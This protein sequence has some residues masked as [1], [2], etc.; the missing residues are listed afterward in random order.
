M[1]TIKHIT[2]IGCLI[3]SG[4]LLSSCSSGTIMDNPEMYKNQVRGWIDRTLVDPK[5][6]DAVKNL[7]VYYMQTHNN[8]K[9]RYYLGEALDIKPDDPELIFYKGLNLEFYNQPDK[10]ISFYEKYKEVPEDS[11]Y[12]ELLEGRYLWIKRQQNYSD[13]SSLIQNEK[14]LTFNNVSDSTMAVFPLIYDGTNK[15]YAPL[16]RGFSEMVSIDL[17]KLKDI[18]VLERVRIQAVLDELKLSQSKEV[19]QSTA[20]RV[21]KI[22]K[23]GTIV[24]GDYDVT[25]NGDFKI[26]LGSWEVE[27]SQRKSWVNKS[28]SLKDLF[29][30]QKQVVFAFLQEN[31]FQLTQED[32]EK[33]AYIPTQNLEAFLAY[34]KGLQE[35]D[36]GNY[37]QAEGF[38][39]QASQLDPHFQDAGSKLQST[40][41]ISKSGG[42]KEDLVT[43][44]RKTLPVVQNEMINLTASRSTQ[45]GNNITAN[46]VQGVDSRSPAQEASEQVGLTQELPS[47]P[48]PP[49]PPL[50]K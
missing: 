35:E 24:S 5:D 18:T 29:V 6:F 31:G 25:E 1:K 12:R 10:A 39:N 44:L 38:F 9:A 15:D 4:M 11:P 26:N 33:I 40:Q 41:S 37:Q 27:T 7:S 8:D 17:A 23:A 49:P 48:P 50:G 30:L 20:P 13:V 34:S 14:D 19:D 3:L 2:I 28:G 36:A 16:S 22:L 43:T 32:K 42:T 47:P 46:F 45:L 21:G